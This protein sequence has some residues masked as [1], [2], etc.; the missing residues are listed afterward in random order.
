MMSPGDV[1][2]AP[3]KV[4]GSQGGYYHHLRYAHQIGRN[5]EKLEDYMAKNIPNRKGKSGNR[6]QKKVEERNEDEDD[7]DNE[8]NN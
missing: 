5:G 3:T 7:N 1:P 4:Y 2:F 8:Q 6:K